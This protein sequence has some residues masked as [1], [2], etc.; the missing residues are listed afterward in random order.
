MPDA[1]IIYSLLGYI[2]AAIIY[3]N[4]YWITLTE[5][6]H[7]SII[8]SETHESRGILLTLHYI[9]ARGICM[10]LY[11]ICIWQFL[12]LFQYYSPHIHT[13]LSTVHGNARVPIKYQ[14]KSI[15]NCKI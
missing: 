4:G 7:S 12:L 9:K 15:Y 10:S 3:T 6:Y 11:Y 14:T 1:S 8:D 13:S 5:A 2:K